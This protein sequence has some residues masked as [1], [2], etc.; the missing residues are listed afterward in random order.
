[1]SLTLTATEARKQFFDL[2]KDINKHHQAYHIHH[3]KG[4]VVL[5]SEEDYENLIETL[6]L[7]SSKDFRKRLKKSAAQAKKGELLSMDDVFGKE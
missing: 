3:R 2:L 7:L 6:E 1:M 5:L 4:N